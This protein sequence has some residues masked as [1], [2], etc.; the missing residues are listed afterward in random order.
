MPQRTLRGVDV[1]KGMT[2]PAGATQ[3]ERLPEKL[4]GYPTFADFIAK[5]KDAAIYR[6]YERLSARNL[7]YQQSEL[8][9]LERQ[10]E[11]I[12][13][14]DAKDIDNQ[15]AH[16]AAVSWEHYAKSNSEQAQ[17]RRKLQAEIA[18]KIKEYRR[19][20]GCSFVVFR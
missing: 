15:E 10:L 6:K 11:D 20:P 7:L 17:K 8:H 9:E 3:V 19:H 2:S 13:R 14:D 5:D 4:A 18:Q 1:E 12:D 16:A